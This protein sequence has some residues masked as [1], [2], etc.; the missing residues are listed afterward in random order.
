[1]SFLNAFF[2]LG[3]GA[4]AVPIIIHLVSRL[5]YTRMDFSSAQFLQHS[6]RRTSRKLQPINLFLLLIRIALLA[7]FTLALA[8]P[9]LLRAASGRQTTESCTAIIIDN[10]YSMGYETGNQTRLD[11]AKR[12]ARQFIE[13]MAD[14]DRAV[15]L[16]MSDQVSAVV[17]EPVHD[18]D[19]LL[20]AVKRVSLSNRGTDALPA[21]LEA[22]E[23]LQ[24]AGAPFRRILMLTDLQRNGWT[25][26]DSAHMS[27]ARRLDELLATSKSSEDRI[28]LHILNCATE[29]YQ[30]LG[31]GSIDSGEQIL[32]AGVP[33]KIDSSILVSGT[34]PEMHKANVALSMGDQSA[35][36]AAVPLGGGRSVSAEF[37]VKVESPGPC[38][39][40][41]ELPPDG[42]AIDNQYHF[43]IPVSKKRRVLL[44]RR[45]SRDRLSSG[46]ALALALRSD[47]ERASF[48]ELRETTGAG[49]G[50][51]HLE[52]VDVVI[53]ADEC[54]GLVAD[55]LAEFVT[56]GGGL[57]VFPDAGPD[58]L[59]ERFAGHTGL[60]LGRFATGLPSPEGVSILF[61]GT[62]HGGSAFAFFARRPGL[63]RVVKLQKCVPLQ[64]DD[65]QGTRVIATNGS[66]RVLIAEIRIGRGRVL[67]FGFGCG[68]EWGNV[69][70]TAAQVPLLGQSILHVASDAR[71][72]PQTYRIGARVQRSFPG[73]DWRVRVEMPSGEKPEIP[74][75]RADGET[76]CDFTDT[77]VPGRY[78][79][80]AES[81]S[82]RRVERFVVNLDTRE[83]VLVPASTVAI[84]NILP[85][86]DIR[87]VPPGREAAMLGAPAD[88]VP[89]RSTLLLAAVL[90]LIMEGCLA[91][92]F[93][94]GEEAMAEPVVA[95]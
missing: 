23:L 29:S 70:L 67:A 86:A 85:R 54:P 26:S 55:T 53:L 41:V 42:L 12:H 9:L 78:V 25:R 59:N 40:R 17:E 3:L 64:L 77:Q 68:L 24:H 43:S 81:S 11:R 48:V 63:V 83:S 8:R 87:F 6:S 62:A 21:L 89:L 71:T 7:A 45:A 60:L 33:F 13:E 15:L 88:K 31:I 66:G 72:E 94:R 39:G 58:W 18:K 37:S 51:R 10:S 79:L 91:S 5:R 49:A 30:N 28:R 69:P 1:V 2:L 56:R 73:E 20:E 80:V 52:H 32:V 95:E 46:T 16:T 35:A 57:I 36:K 27:L 47:K 90:L 61:Q 75:T 82:E 38:E 19:V 93:Y 84:K 22:H 92:R 44:V 14:E 76:S 65:R 34:Y 74:V 50:A 4:I